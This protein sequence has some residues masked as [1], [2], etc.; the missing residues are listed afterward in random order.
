MYSLRRRIVIKKAF[1]QQGEKE[2]QI[3]RQRKIER[4][5]EG[6]RKIQTERDNFYIQSAY[7]KYTQNNKNVLL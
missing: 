7:K 5:I 2:N 4:K 6:D 1:K 3:D